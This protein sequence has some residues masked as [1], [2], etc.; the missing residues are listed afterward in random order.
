MTSLPPMDRLCHQA[1]TNGSGGSPT[2]PPERADSLR[3]RCDDG[4]R[5][6]RDEE[7]VELKDYWLTVRRRW[8][9]IVLVVAV[10]VAAAA[11]YTWQATPQDASTASV[12]V[13]PSPSDT[14]DA[15]QGNLFA[16]QRI[17]SYAE[18]VGKRRLAERV[19]GDLGGG[20][21]PATLQGAVSTSVNPDTVIL[22]ITATY[23]DPVQ[24]RDI[25]QA[26]A[27]ALSTE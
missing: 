5:P 22:D 10:C 1:V 16:T 13:P 24:A 19:A 2:T 21:S 18:L 17:N 3:R 26:Y 8:R 4:E 7:R 27:E 15:Y 9:I 11:A 12:F 23:P 25:A 6:T 14:A 20:L